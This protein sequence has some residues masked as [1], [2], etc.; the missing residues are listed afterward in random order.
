MII[1]TVTIIGFEIPNEF[2]LQRQFEMREDLTKWKKSQT[3]GYVYYTKR[4]YMTC[5]NKKD[6]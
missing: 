1:S 3:T 5:I 6:S 4:D 2:E